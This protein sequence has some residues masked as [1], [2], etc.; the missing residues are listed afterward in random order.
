[1]QAQSSPGDLATPRLD[2][3]L[4]R[5]GSGMRGLVW[6]HGLGSILFAAGLWLAFAYL[7]DRTLHLPTALRVLHGALLLGIPLFL[8]RREVILALRRIPDRHGLAMLLERGHEGA[9]D[10]LVSALS[11]R[12]IS[13]QD[14]ARPLVEALVHEAEELAST[15]DTGRALDPRG[16][17]KRLGLGLLTATLASALLLSNPA[18]GAI[19]LRRAIGQDVAWPRRTNLSVELSLPVGVEVD[20]STPG[21]L[22]ARIARGSD[23]TLLVSAEGEVPDAITLN[24]ANGTRSVVRTAGAKSVRP[25]LRNMQNSEQLWITGGDDERGL[26]RIELEVLEPPD[27]SELAFI[28]TPPGY[29]GLERTVVLGTEVRALAGSRIDVLI[30]P[31]PPGATGVLRVLGEEGT[32]ELTPRPWSLPGEAPQGPALGCSLD[33]EVERYFQVELVDERGLSNPDPGTY[34]LAVIPDRKPEVILLAPGS[35]EWSVV[36]GGAIPLR[37]R[38]EDDFHVDHMSFDVRDSQNLE[39]AL[40]EEELTFQDTAPLDGNFMDSQHLVLAHELLELTQIAGAEVEPGWSAVLQVVARDSHPSPDHQAMSAPVTLRCVSGDDF[41][42]KVK[43]GLARAGEDAARLLHETRNLRT[44][45][46]QLMSALETGE[47]ATDQEI[48]SLLN[49]TRRLQGDTRG[50]GRDL[51]GLAEGLVYSRLDERAGPLLTALHKALGAQAARTF[52]PV[53]WRDVAQQLSAGRLGTPELAGEL[54]TLVDLALGISEDSADQAAASLTEARTAHDPIAAQAAVAR[55]IEALDLALVALEA[56]TTRLGEWD[57]FQSVLTLTK[58]LLNRQK[59]LT[60]R[61]KKFAE[62]N[63]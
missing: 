38:A 17:R 61:T 6:Q 30:R 10:R 42:R 50:I 51:S 13:T 33:V 5:L 22:R 41:L 35:N 55:G 14:P 8:L 48:G 19:F 24:F 11:L 47:V 36:Q 43:D 53:P 28:V 4:N 45:A 15:L 39:E 34:A 7:A 44:R 2:Q 59:N 31:G 9:D 63:K 3:A 49:S 20:A 18:L 60:E 56:L 54:L 52:D 12:E 16:P 57:N 23:V 37:V 27:I 40:L 29:S 1:M 25:S 46:G 32:I 26:P 62:G 21:I 58:D